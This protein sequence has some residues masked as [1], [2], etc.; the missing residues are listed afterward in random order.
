MCT[1]P[2][3]VFGFGNGASGEGGMLSGGVLRRDFLVARNIRALRL[4]HIITTVITVTTHFR[5]LT[6]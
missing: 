4:T 2:S 5:Y 3:G 1:P 6:L